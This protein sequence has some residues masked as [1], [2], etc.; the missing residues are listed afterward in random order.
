MSLDQR[1][2]DALDF[3]DIVSAARQ[4]GEESP[5]EHERLEVAQLRELFARD[6]LDD[7]CRIDLLVFD[8]P[9]DGSCGDVGLDALTI[10]ILLQSPLRRAGRDDL[11]SRV[12]RG[13]L[14]VVEKSGINKTA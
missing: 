10:Q 8:D 12:L 5:T 3:I 11:R 4:E 13:I 7:R 9:S 2:H 14:G 1:T 6:L